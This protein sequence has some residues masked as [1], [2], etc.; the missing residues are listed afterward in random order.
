MTT[1]DWMTPDWARPN[2]HP[3]SLHYDRMKGCE[4]DGG[5]IERRQTLFWHDYHCVMDKAQ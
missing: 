5:K 1:P 4:E 3:P 2:P